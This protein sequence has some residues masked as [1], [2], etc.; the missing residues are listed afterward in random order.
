MLASS[1]EITDPCPVPLSLTVTTPP[2]MTPALSHFWIRRISPSCCGSR[3]RAHPAH[4]ACRVLA[5]THTT[6]RGS[7]PRRSRSAARLPPAGRSCPPGQPQSHRTA[8]L[9]HQPLGSAEVIHPFH[10]LRGQ[11]F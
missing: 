5:G 7:P 2:S 9:S 11:R 8:L 1:G 4:H 10:P 6:L 3:R